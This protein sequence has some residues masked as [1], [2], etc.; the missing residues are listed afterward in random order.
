MDMSNRTNHAD[1]STAEMRISGIPSIAYRWCQ[2]AHGKL[3][4][5]AE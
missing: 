4:K 3:M 5:N 2:Y 1:S